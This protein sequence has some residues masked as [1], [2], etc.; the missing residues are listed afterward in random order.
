MS[1]QVHNFQTGETIE[2]PPINE[3]DA[4]I[5]INENDIQDVKDNMVLISDEPPQTST[6]KLWIVEGSEVEIQIPSMQDLNDVVGG[7]HGVPAGGRSGQVLSKRTGVNY[8][9][10][11]VDPAGTSEQDR[12]HW[13]LQSDEIIDTTQS[14]VFDQQGNIS[15]ITHTDLQNEVVR[16]DS[17]TFGENTIT[18]VRTLSTGESLTLATN[19]TTLVTTVTYAE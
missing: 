13:L 19:L 2:A 14:I 4:Q 7:I 18:E 1:Y 12:I 9:M 11:W 10:R 6:N 8:D 3:M 16:T 17:F 5:R 15:S